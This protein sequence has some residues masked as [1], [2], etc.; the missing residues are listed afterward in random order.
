MSRVGTEFPPPPV[1][2][3]LNEVLDSYLL[4]PETRLPIHQPEQHKV[5]YWERNP[6]PQRLLHSELKPVQTT[7]KVQRDLATGE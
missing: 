6:N 7:L 3:T 2:N 5:N 1:V 4:C